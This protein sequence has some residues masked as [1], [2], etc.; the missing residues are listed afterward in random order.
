V[1]E[2][3]IRDAAHPF[4]ETALPT[5][6]RVYDTSDEQLAIWTTNQLGILLGNLHNQVATHRASFEDADG[7]VKE[8]DRARRDGFDAVNAIKR[9]K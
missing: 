5:I 8:I 3:S 4:L 1:A 6:E 2:Q 9:R 7:L